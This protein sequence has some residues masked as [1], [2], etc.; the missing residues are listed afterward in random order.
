MKLYA[1]RDW[2]KH[3]ENSRTRKRDG[4]GWVPI[5][6]RFGGDHY[7]AI[8]AHRD[9]PVIFT[10]FILMVELASHCVPRGT[11][12]RSNGQPHTPQTMSVKCHCPATWFVTALSYLEQHTDWLVVTHVADGPLSHDTPLSP[13]RQPPVTELCR[14]VPARGQLSASERIT[15][16]KELER[17]EASIKNLRANRPEKPAASDKDIAEWSARLNHMKGRKTELLNLLGMAV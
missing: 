15:R 16:E 8:M 4:L 3:Y 6:N 14:V 5:P 9:A 1:I 13:P 11:L 2:D 7:L 10:G 12:I 17:V